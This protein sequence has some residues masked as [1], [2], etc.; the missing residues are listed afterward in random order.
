MIG[1]VVKLFSELSSM[2]A[3]FCTWNYL[4]YW[5][6]ALAKGEKSLAGQAVIS[7]LVKWNVAA[8]SVRCWKSHCFGQ[9]VM[10]QYQQMSWNVLLSRRRTR[11]PR[12]GRKRRECDENLKYAVQLEKSGGV[13]THTAS[14]SSNSFCVNVL[15]SYSTN[16]LEQVYVH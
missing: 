11:F 4:M 5:Y 2:S 14:R 15:C 9:L 1:H 16:Y 6:L 12:L 13:C 3:P 10:N 8:E 7:Q